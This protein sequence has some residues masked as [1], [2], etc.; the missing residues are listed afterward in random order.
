M[1]SQKILERRNRNKHIRDVT[2]YNWFSFR[3]GLASA[4]GCRQIYNLSAKLS[5]YTQNKLIEDGFKI[6]SNTWIKW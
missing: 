4:I 6:T 5:I 1:K 2:E 3:I